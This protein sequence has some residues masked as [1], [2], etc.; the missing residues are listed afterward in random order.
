MASRAAKTWDQAVTPVVALEV[1]TWV[2]TA[3]PVDV[4]V[5]RTSV[6]AATPMAGQ[7]AMAMVDPMAVV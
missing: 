7:A 2:E 4:Q 1:R 5:D 6:P 3:T